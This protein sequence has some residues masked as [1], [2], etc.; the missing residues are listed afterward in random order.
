MGKDKVSTQT[1]EQTG[2]SSTGIDQASQDYITNF[3]RPLG[4][5]GA[6][7]V[8]GQ[9][10]PFFNG[11]TDQFMQGL[12]GI[13]NV[14]QQLQGGGF[15]QALQDFQG[16][17][18]GTG[19]NVGQIGDGGAMDIFRQMQ[20]QNQRNP[21]GALGFSAGTFD[22]NRAQSFFS[23]YEDQ[24]VG[25]VQAN[26]DRQRTQAINR[27][28]QEATAAGAFGGSRSGMLQSQALRDVN[29]DE[30]AQ[31]AS[32]RNSGFQNAMGQALGAFNTEQATGLGA[33]T[34]AMQGRLQDRAGMLAGG[35]QAAGMGQQGAIAQNELGLRNAMANQQGRQFD[36]SNML[37]RALGLQSGNLQGLG[38]Q[39]SAAQG[40]MQG[41]EQLR[42]IQNQQAQEQ[43]FRYQ[44]ALGLGQGGFGQ[45]LGSTTDT[46]MSGVTED[47]QKGDLFGDLMGLG[48]TAGGMF[49]G[50]P[51]GAA[52]AGGLP[53]GGTGSQIAQQAAPSLFGGNPLFGGASNSQGMGMGG[54]GGNPYSSLFGGMFGPGQMNPLYGGG[55]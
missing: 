10:N 22:P 49:L 17:S 54:G 52:A 15:N 4:Q 12:G 8:L 20:A 40:L 50:G 53:G 14:L 5:Q 16:N 47:R 29:Q 9:E 42:G 38:Q 23:P 19:F 25:G 21:A 13:G 18:G 3:L 48:L 30:A 7:A 41:G 28:G 31:V 6:E 46:Q 44:Q 33:A 35:L 27:A 37:Q 34:A 39:Q 24:V 32:L 36:Q 51:A 1:Q 11:P 2:S 43:L 55:R 26:A 45:T